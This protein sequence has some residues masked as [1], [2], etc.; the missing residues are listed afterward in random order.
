MTV[1]PRGSDADPRPVGSA[2]PDQ[3]SRRGPTPTS[4]PRCAR[5]P[6]PAC[7]WR[8]VSFLAC[9]IGA[10]SASLAF[11]PR[12]GAELPSGAEPPLLVS[13]VNLKALSD[14]I[15]EMDIAAA[16]ALIK[17]Y[18]SASLSVV[19][20]QRLALERARLALYVADCDSADA[21]LSPLPPDEPQRAS[22]ADLALRCSRATAAG[23]VVEDKPRGVWLRIQDTRD[24][25]LAPYIAEVAAKA[26][27]AI[28]YDLGVV[29]PRPLRID[30]V[31]DLFSLSAVSGLPVEAAE[32]TG[33]VA[34]ARWGRV[35][36]LSPQAARHGYPWE[37]TLA[38][39]I[40]HLAL[41]RGTRDHAP[42]WLQEGVAKR[43]E[44]RW[45]DSRPFDDPDNHDR[46]A[47]VALESGN[48][49]GVDNLGPSIAMLPSADAAAIAFSEVTS[50]IS[51]WINQNGRPA[52][53]LLLAD[54][55]GGDNRDPDPALRSV[56]GYSLK[57][58]IV[59]WQAYLRQ[60][61]LGDIEDERFFADA[62]ARELSRGSRLGDLLFQGQHFEA[63]AQ[64]F[65]D[66]HALAPRL[67]AYRVRLSQA[68]LAERDPAAARAA[69]G[70]MDDLAAP[71]GAWLAL[72][73]RFVLEDW[74]SGAAAAGARDPGPQAQRDLT[75]ALGMDPWSEVVACEGYSEDQLGADPWLMR[76][77]AT[78]E[79]QRLC[80]LARTRPSVR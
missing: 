20:A 61:E 35:T 40:V 13:S 65:A 16:T 70:G 73:A 49:V 59:R 76:T 78:P 63:A 22:M 21:I 57:E 45:R 77:P 9:V 32:T 25:G 66:A 39:E 24:E 29:L 80:E 10:L 50:F 41:S 69:L 6:T 68:R 42:L 72:H 56:S 43:G 19:D 34:V 3:Q 5:G 14:A 75:W 55:K 18:S 38:H 71:T 54:L 1:F 48:S 62:D 67:P 28:E 11:L 44:L 7:M 26:R 33:T 60:L 23:L 12:A 30:L 52:L 2:L 15:T 46:V 51:Y 74:S 64:Y 31:R 27:D 36:L 8:P 47:K 17:R 58:W 37:D 4:A 79:R 53:H